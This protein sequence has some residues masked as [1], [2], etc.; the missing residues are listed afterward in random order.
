[1]SKNYLAEGF[2]KIKMNENCS[3]EIVRKIRGRRK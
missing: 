1:M 3:L 2:R